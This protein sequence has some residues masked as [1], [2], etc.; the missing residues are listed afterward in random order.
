MTVVWMPE[1]DTELP[2]HPVTVMVTVCDCV[3][4]VELPVIDNVA[5]LIACSSNKQNQYGTYL[6]DCRV[7]NHAYNCAASLN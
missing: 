7:L 2:V 3:L 4:G 6:Q 1:T 5:V